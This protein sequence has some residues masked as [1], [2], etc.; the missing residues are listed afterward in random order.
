MHRAGAAALLLV[1]SVG[2]GAAIFGLPFIL[3]LVGGF[4]HWDGLA[5]PSWAG[6][7]NFEFLLFRDPAFWPVLRNTL[8]FAG[9]Q[10]VIGVPLAIGFALLV[11]KSGRRT[12][13]RAVYWLPMITNIVAVAYMWSFLLDDGDGLLD[14]ALSLFGVQPVG[15]LTDPD[16]ALWS[17][18]GIFVWMHLGQ[19]MLIIADALDRIDPA[20][21]E[22]ARLDGAGERRILRHILLPLLKPTLLFVSVTSIIQAMSYF[23]LMLVLTNG[24]PAGATEVLSLSIYRTAFDDLRIG[25]AM[26]AGTI[27][28]ALVFTLTIIQ[29]RAMRRGALDEVGA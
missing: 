7:R 26:A 16:V 5:A 14:R 20:M 1:P 25:R 10:L 23:V 4:A 27:L 28:L 8:L 19:Q 21:I 9:A 6:L 15:W 3:A 24:G 13:W 12:L 22:A 11:D 2:V 17:L 18:V 29:M